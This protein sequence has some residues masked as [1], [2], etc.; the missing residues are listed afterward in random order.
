[1]IESTHLEE[2]FGT[3]E[4]D[5]HAEAWRRLKQSDALLV[6]G[7]FGIRGIEGKI[8]AIRHARENKMPFLGVCLGMQAAVIEYTRSFLGRSLA[9]SQEFFPELEGE[10][11]AV[12]FMPEGDKN[13]MGG[14]MRLGARTTL[15]SADSRAMRLYDGAEEVSERHRHR[16]E[17]NPEL[18]DKLEHQGMNIVVE[19]CRACL[20]HFT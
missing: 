9:N 2:D 4:P 8:L 6:P 3:T 17:V 14:T 1:M 12:I 16:Y 10:D 5:L 20:I 13:V 19:V 7:G 18:V 15:I 11:A